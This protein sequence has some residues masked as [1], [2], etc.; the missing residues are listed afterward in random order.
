MTICTID[1]HARDVVAKLIQQKVENAQAFTWLCQLRHRW[2]GSSHPRAGQGMRRGR[3][4]E[5]LAYIV[6]NVS[7]CLE[8]CCHA[9]PSHRCR[10]EEEK[11][12]CFANICDAEFKY[13]YEYLG[14]T[15][16][17]GVEQQM[18]QRLSSSYSLIK[19]FE[20]TVAVWN[21]DTYISR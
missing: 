13:S 12:D 6:A 15:P 1:V 4:G 14:K 19:V 10:W 17:G 9:N 3:G 16:P 2:V 20:T 8:L 21:K 11:T 7:T 5:E 18:F